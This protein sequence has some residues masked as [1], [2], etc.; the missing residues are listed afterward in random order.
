MALINCPACKHELS[1]RAAACPHCGHACHTAKVPRDWIAPSFAVLGTLV[2]LSAGIY[3]VGRGRGTPLDDPGIVREANREIAVPKSPP[4]N[5][6]DPDDFER[7]LRWIALRVQPLF[8]A[9]EADNALLTKER[10]GEMHAEFA[11][12]I[13]GRKVRWQIKV[14]R[15]DEKYVHLKDYALGDY[16][17]HNPRHR[18]DVQISAVAGAEPPE[19]LEPYGRW[20]GVFGGVSGWAFSPGLGIGEAI[21]K[22]SA[23]LLAKGDYVLINGK[24]A[25]CVVSDR[26]G[27]RRT[28]ALSIVEAKCPD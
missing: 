18:C 10:A 20:Y 4:L 14:D 26:A 9:D 24:I 12:V 27:S 5:E 6:F 15:V 1:D 8:D 19:R 11:K 28:C 13:A 22:D 16:M 7:T 23:K 25:F 2:L 17:S 3:Y 21:S